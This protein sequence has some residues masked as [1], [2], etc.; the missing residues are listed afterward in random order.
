M[1]LLKSLCLAIS[2]LKVASPVYAADKL[3]SINFE[4]QSLWTAV[5]ELG[6]QT[7][8]TFGI[9]SQLPVRAGLRVELRQVPVDA[10]LRIFAL[11]YEV[12]VARSS[13]VVSVRRCEPQKRG[14]I[15]H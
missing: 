2:L 8:L 5:D 10:A 7:G 13:Q 9:D 15:Y 14:T 6:K 1:S 12:C 4:H 11:V 3:V